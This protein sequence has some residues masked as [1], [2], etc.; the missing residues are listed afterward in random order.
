[1]EK[2][3]INFYVQETAKCPLTPAHYRR[4]MDG[5]QESEMR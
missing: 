4:E 5:F 2:K 1:M 3:T